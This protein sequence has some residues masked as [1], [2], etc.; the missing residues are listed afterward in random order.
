MQRLSNKLITI[1]QVIQE[2]D[3]AY[4][5]IYSKRKKRGHNDDIWHLV[6][7]WDKLKP[8]IINSLK[9]DN[10][11]LSPMQHIPIEGAGQVGIWNAQDAI[12]LKALAIVMTPVIKQNFDLKN[13]THL[14]G[15]GGLKGA[16]EKAKKA[17]VKAERFVY[18]TDI[19]DFYKSIDH[20]I[21]LKQLTKITNDEC[22]LNL[23][24]QYCQRVD[25]VNGDYLCVDDKG[26]PKGC[27]LSP[28]MGAIYLS[29]IDELAKKY[30]LTYICYMDDLLF[31]SDKRWHLKK[32][33][34]QLHGLLKK[35]KQTLSIPKT[36]VGRVKQGF[37][38]LGFH[39]KVTSITVA[40]KTWLNHLNKIVRLYEQ[41][42]SVEVIEQYKFRWNVWVRGNEINK[43]KF[44]R[45]VVGIYLF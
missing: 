37:D 42:A 17:C 35:L 9:Q 27:A 25:I 16:I 4:H 22:V 34:K 7:H 15:H 21:L 32:L 18:K 10:Y 14:K 5:Y 44:S 38:W 39:I 41:G 20:Q 12:V 33:I 8:E 11:R 31:I 28:L 13:V 36:W 24:K 19:K 3:N 43:L 6:F 29:P 23:C 26:I 30:K 45:Y 1:D 40:M 2:I